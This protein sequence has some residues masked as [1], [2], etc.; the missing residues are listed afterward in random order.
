LYHQSGIF[1]AFRKMKLET[2][3]AS[4][5]ELYNFDSNAVY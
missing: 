2:L 3:D 1:I 4:R 5:Y